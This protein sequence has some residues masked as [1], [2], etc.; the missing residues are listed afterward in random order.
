LPTVLDLTTVGASGYINSALFQEFT[1]SPTGSGVIS[2]FVR[3]S[4]NSA[5]EQGYN[6]DF[7]PVQ[8]DET[9]SHSFTRAIQLSSLPMV[10]APGGIAYYEFLLDINQSSSFPHNLLSLDELRLYVTNSSTKDPNLLHNYNSST[11]TLQDD[12]GTRYSPVYDLNPVTDSNY[13]KLDANLSSGTGVGDMVALIPVSLLGTDTNQYVY[14]YSEFGVHFANTSG[15]EQWAAGPA[16]P[17]GTISGLKFVDVNG[18]GARD[19]GEPGLAGVT[20][21]LDANNNGVLDP[22]EVSTVTAADGTFSFSNLLAGTYHVREVVP[23]AYVQTAQLKADATLA[24]GQN[25]TGVAFGNF[26]LGSISGTL[27]DDLTGDGFTP[28][29]PVLNSANP[30]FVPVTIQLSQGSTLLATTTTNTSGTYT[31]TG[32]GPGTYTVNEV[33]PNGWIQTASTG[34][35]IVATSG[36]AATSNFDIFKAASIVNNTL[37]LSTTQAGGG[38]LDVA[39]NSS[40]TTNVTLRG[41]NAGSFPTTGL[42]T[43]QIASFGGYTVDTTQVTV[44]PVVIIANPGN[45]NYVAGSSNTTVNLNSGSTDTISVTGGV[46]TLSFSATTFGVTFNDSLNTLVQG[47]YQLQSLDSSGTHFLGVAGNFQTVIGTNF[48]DTITGASNTTVF[49]GGGNDS[50]FAPAGGANMSFNGGNGIDT[51]TANSGNVSAISFTGTNADTFIADGAAVTGVS[52]TG[53]IGSEFIANSGSVTSVSFTGTANDIFVANGAVVTGVSFTGGSN[54]DQFIANGGTV[55]SVSFTGGTGADTFLV[56]GANVTGVSFTGGSSTDTFIA[57]SGSVSGVSFTGGNMAD[58][59]IANGA[60]VSNVSFTGGNGNDAFIANNGNVSSISFNGG[61]GTDIFIANGAAVNGVSFTGTGSDGFIAN[62]GT[63]TNVSFT[64]GNGV[65]QFIANGASTVSNISFT[66]G[67]SNDAFIASSGNVSSIS[68]NG[69]AGTDTFL[70]NGATVNGVSFTGTGTDLFIANTGSVSSV[71]FNGGNGGD[72]FLASNNATVSNVSFSGGTGADSFVASNG[73]AVSNVSF[74]GGGGGPDQFIVNSANLTNATFTAGSGSDTLFITNSSTVNTIRFLGDGSSDAFIVNGAS[75]LSNATFQGASGSDAFV[76]NDATVTN[77][78]FNGGSNTN[79]FVLDGGTA[80]GVNFDTDSGTATA[81]IGGSMTG[82]LAQGTGNVSFLFF[83]SPGSNLAQG[84]IVIDA[85][86]QLAAKGSSTG[87]GTLD[88]SGYMAAGINLSLQAAKANIPQTV[89][90]GLTLTFA[91][92]EAFTQVVGTPFADQIYGNDRGDLLQG[93]AM[94]DPRDASAASLVPVAPTQWELVVFGPPVNPTDHTYT[95]AEQAQTVQQLNALYAPFGFVK[96][97]QNISDIPVGTTYAT[98]TFNQSGPNPIDSNEAGGVSTELDPRNVSLGAQTFVNVNG[99]LGGPGQP[100]NTSQNF[101]AASVGIAAH[102]VAHTLGVEHYDSFGPIGFGT[103][104]FPAADSYSPS[105]PGPEAAFETFS[106]LIASPASVDSSLFNLVAGP[107]LGEREAIK[108]AFD[109]FANQPVSDSAYNANNPVPVVAETAGAHTSQASALGLGLA[110]IPVPNKEPAGA[111]YAG[112]LFNVAAVDVVGWLKTAR[113]SD[114]YTITGKKGDL[115]TL[116]VYSQDIIRPTP[117]PHGDFDANLTVLD[118]SGNPIAYYNSTAFNDDTNNSQSAQLADPRLID[119]RLPADGTYYVVVG[120]NNI[121]FNTGDYELFIYRFSASNPVSGNDLLVGGAGNDTL[122]GG[123]GNDTL[124]GG[125]GNNFLFGGGGVNTVQESGAT[126][127]TLTNSV[128]ASTTG[129]DTLQY[130][131]NAV[132]TG[133]ASGTTFNV[134]NWTGT[135][136]LTGVGGVNSVIATRDT[137]FT[138][139]NSVLILTNGGTFTLANIQ[140]ATLTG[141]PSANSFDVGGWTGVAFLNGAGGTDTVVAS[142]NAAKFVLTDS[143]ISISSGGTFSLT[144]IQNAILTGAPSGTTFDVRHWSGTDT[145]NVPGGQNPVI[146]P[147]GVA[148]NA[149]EAL[150]SGATA[151]FT[152]GGTTVATN[153]T[154]TIDWGNTSTSLG[155]FSSSGNQVS[156]NGNHTYDEGNYTVTTTFSQGS[157][158]SVIVS[159]LASVADAPLTASSSALIQPQGILLNKQV[160]SFTDADSAGTIR[161]FTASINWGDGVTS[162]GTV[163]QPNGLGTAF[164]VTGSHTYGVAA[165]VTVT[166]TI[167]DVGG[168]LA[169]TNFTMTVQPS[170]FVLN[171]T[172]AGALTVTG[173]TGLNVAGAIVVDSTSTSAFSAKGN[174]QIT[175]STIQVVGGASI[176][177]G[178]LVSPAPTT[179]VTSIP[180]PLSGLSAPPAGTNQGAKIF[181]SGSATLGPGTYS[182][183]S[184]S[185]NGT[186]LVLSPGIYILTGGGFSVTNAASVTG[187]GVVMYN[188]GSN[189]PNSGGTFG[190]ISLSSSGTINLSAPTTGPYA[191]VL[192]FQSRDNARTISLSASSA[193]GLS[194]TIYAPAALLSLAGSSTFSDPAIVNLL[195]VNGNGG[196]PLMA[197]GADLSST[198]NDGQLQ[199]K[200]L[201]LY[202]NDSN[203]YFTDAE[204]ARLQDAIRGLDSLLGPYGVT[205]SEVSNLASANLVLDAGP[206]SASGGLADGVLGNYTPSAP[207]GI[208]TVIEGWN[209]YAGA[210]PTGIGPGQYDFQTVVTHEFGH[211]LG[212]AHDENPNSVMYDALAAGATR[213]WLTAQELNVAA[214]ATATNTIQPERSLSANVT[215]VFFTILLDSPGDGSAA[216]HGPVAASNSVPLSENS[217]AVS[218][219]G[220]ELSWGLRE[221]ATHEQGEQLLP[222]G[223]ADRAI[224]DESS[225]DEISRDLLAANGTEK[226]S[227][228]QAALAT[229]LQERAITQAAVP[230]LPIPTTAEGSRDERGQR[231]RSPAGSSFVILHPSSHSE[232]AAFIIVSMLAMPPKLLERRSIDRIFVERS[233]RR[234]YNPAGAV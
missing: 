187:M 230:H 171:P 147:R 95:L 105:Y 206:A 8:F 231:K 40:N 120:S 54:S 103:N 88:F 117:L 188:A 78:T 130:I 59:F 29:D 153:Y 87:N 149:T 100:A 15:F 99:F 1:P 32:L 72:V 223:G 154:D 65:D 229:V 184:V 201:L 11:H 211:A 116:Q 142:V 132:L 166:V 183:I 177:G 68:F 179:G 12:A 73:A 162:A 140:Q 80:T 115:I 118:A 108:I 176:S 86:A 189:F 81:A 64:G 46:N 43:I 233:R 17:V 93:A 3:L 202:V 217:G 215:S 180:D 41:Q 156:V 190:A 66:G 122:I 199:R 144:N 193:V 181:S 36:F 52:F 27:F 10:V 102:E 30:D 158:F 200:N 203:G 63:V 136:T 44:T 126:A 37:K 218:R 101:V 143:N 51:L 178:A 92:P 192:I 216:V 83:G 137:N 146:T 234:D 45:A 35:T 104:F 124:I 225:L 90:A 53:G 77:L 55:S 85:D 75:S 20:V 127:Y 131:S 170:L 74:N 107:Y 210:D 185:G 48:N 119:L 196:Q 112:K 197:A 114:Y 69:G 82:T 39:Q 23:P 205:I 175:A 134:S 123:S 207:Y 128:L 182:Q 14:L 222:S 219:N 133:S 38:V 34:T 224:L 195:T 157:A 232:L 209:W 212:L 160:T 5:V 89:T 60:T 186:S 151:T 31:F 6:T 135:G 198:D 155:S 169:T 19:A 7:R 50:F 173:T 84:N 47:Q 228:R 25:A 159:S 172:A 227:A 174:S 58:L 129:T 21:F 138:L 109:E 28:D 113:T 9:T 49:G 24:G 91:N 62:S 165:T 13:I 16:L 4:T 214:P 141:G 33:N 42:Q 194:G 18:N 94:P 163:T 2:A 76:A 67:A 164:V 191:G 106:H 168:K 22:G 98:V 167:T 79:D 213:R 148:V 204:Q 150:F 97:T 139:S 61:A 70:A 111:L 161:D 96:F 121:N 71:S 26:K 125:A 152:D 208:I 220:V 56:N 221:S 226:E 110:P 57:N 145:L